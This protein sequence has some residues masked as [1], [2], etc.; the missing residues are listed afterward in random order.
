MKT[1]VLIHSLDYTATPPGPRVFQAAN[2]A[3]A[4][5]FAKENFWLNEYGTHWTLVEQMVTLREVAH[6]SDRHAPEFG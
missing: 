6:F 3:D 1:Y 5:T 4:L 2:D